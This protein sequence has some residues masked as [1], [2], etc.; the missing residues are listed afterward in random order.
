MTDEFDEKAET[1]DDDPGRTARAAE[2][3]RRIRERV[4]LNGDTDVLDFGSGTGLLGFRLLP[5]V[6]SVTFAD[7][8][9]GMLTRVREKLGARG[10]TN[11]LTCRIDPHALDLPRTYDAIVSLMALHHVD[12]PPAVI[13][14][15]ASHVEPGG[16]LALCDL[17]TEDGT[18]HDDF[19][20]HV[21]HG[22]DRDALVSM[23]EELGFEDVEAVTAHVMRREHT[24]GARE[25]P[26]F[27]LT[28]RRPSV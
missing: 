21:H 3:A 5:H 8:S 12:D 10:H 13:R 1:W 4:P 9:E 26:L 20:G 14:F 17:D 11:G 18:F 16:W 15:V 24:D 19:H 23:V 7:P 6:A 22:F 2:V 25:Y 27:L 28:A